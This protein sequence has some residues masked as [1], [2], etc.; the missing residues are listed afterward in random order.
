MTST[1]TSLLE[2]ETAIVTKL[3]ADS[4]LMAIVTGVFDFGSVPTNQPFPYIVTGEDTEGPDNAFGTRGYDASLTLHIWDNLPGFKRCKQILA[5]MNTLL[6]QQSLSLATLKHVYTL[7]DFSTT[8]NDP[9]LD[10]IRHMPV[11]YKTFTQEQ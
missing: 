6:D 1:Q 5:R 4:T 7:Y 9:G 11:R 8:I 2:L 3:L 10:D